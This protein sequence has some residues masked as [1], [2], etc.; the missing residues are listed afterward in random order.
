M[1]LPTFKS[2]ALP[3]EGGDDDRDHANMHAFTILVFKSALECDGIEPVPGGGKKST[4]ECDGIEPVPG[5]G[6]K[7]SLGGGTEPI[8]TVWMKFSS[9][10]FISPSP[11]TARKKPMSFQF[12]FS[13]PRDS[14]IESRDW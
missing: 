4:L 9:A 5:G 6:K 8:P 3:Q 2:S 11:A 14:H 1:P 12:F 13:W 10:D 7:F